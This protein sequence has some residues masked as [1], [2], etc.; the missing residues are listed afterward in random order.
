MDIA[1]LAVQPKLAGHAMRQAV[2]GLRVQHH[3][4]LTS[5]GARKINNAGIIGARQFAGKL[6]GRIA[7]P[8]SEIHP[9]WA[10]VPN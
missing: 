10:L 8:G 2:A 4:R 9:T 7:Q 1:R 6:G 5:C 3:F